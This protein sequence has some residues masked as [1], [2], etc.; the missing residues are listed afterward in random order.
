MS[1]LMR[2]LAEITETTITTTMGHNA[3]SNGVIEIFALTVLEPLHA[4]AF[5]R[6]VR[7]LAHFC[8]SL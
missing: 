4:H 1:E 6:T 7:G 3:R 2:A 5:R 8:R